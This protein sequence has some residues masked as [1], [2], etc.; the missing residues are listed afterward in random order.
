MCE[1]TRKILKG[2]EIGE[3]ARGRDEKHK[4]YR[5]IKLNCFIDVMKD[6][7]FS[8]LEKG[9]LSIFLSFCLLLSKFKFFF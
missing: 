9:K 1:T 7:N 2:R 3:K 6:N 8:A 4:G 5:N